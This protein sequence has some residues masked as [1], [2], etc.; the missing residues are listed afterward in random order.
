MISGLQLKI[1]GHHGAQTV[2]A[3]P[4]QPGSQVVDTRPVNEPV[5]TVVIGT[6]GGMDHRDVSVRRA[7]HWIGT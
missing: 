6:A 1:I 7:L 5:A 3:S 4:E 2:A